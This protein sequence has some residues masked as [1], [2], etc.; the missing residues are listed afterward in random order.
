MSGTRATLR[1]RA[2]LIAAPSV[3]VLVLAAVALG[4][5]VQEIGCNQKAHYALVRAL[6]DGTAIVDEY[7]PES[8]DLA[9]TD[10]HYYA[11]KAPGLAFAVLP[12]YLA[13]DAAGAMPDDPRTAIW[14]LGLFGALVPALLAAA[15]AGRLAERV[16]P[17]TGAFVAAA[18]ALGTLLLPFGTLL[19]AHALAAALALGAFALLW[20]DRPAPATAALAGLLVG[21]AVVVEHPAALVAPV[22]GAYALSRFGARRAGAFAGGAAAGVLPLLAY[23]Y[24]A[25]G[26]VTHFAVVDAISVA[27]NTGHDV[28]G[29]HDR[30]VFGALAPSTTVALEL[31]ASARG[32]LTVTPVVAAGVAGLVLL[33]RRG[34]RAEAF[35][36]AAVAGLYLLWNSG[37]TSPFGGPFGGDSPGARY[38][39]PVLPFLAPGIA[40]ALREAFWPTALLAALSAVF[41]GLAT[42]TEPMLN[43][44]DTGRWWEL[45]SKGEFTGGVVTLLGGPSGVWAVLPFFAGVAAAA[46]VAAVATPR[47]GTTRGALIAAAGVVA[48]WVVVASAAPPLLERGRTL[49]ALAVLL[50]GAAAAYVA[51]R[52][53][54]A[55]R[56]DA[57]A[58]ARAAA[59]GRGARP[60]LLTG[61]LAASVL[62][63]W[64]GATSTAPADGYDGAAHVQYAEHVRETGELPV[65]EDTYE[66]ASPPAFHWLSVRGQEL[67]GGVGDAVEKVSDGPSGPAG[68]VL[69]LALLV[70]GTWLAF[71][72]RRR[73]GVLLLGGAG[74]LLLLEVLV[75]SVA[76]E[77]RIGQ[78]IS[79]ASTAA[80]L[81]LAWLL[82]REAWPGETARPIAVAALAAGMPVL[83]RMGAMFHPEPLFAA[84]ALAAVLVAVRAARREWPLRHAAALGLLLGLGALTRQTT[85]IVVVALA[86]AVAV[87]ARRR[88]LVFG[89]VVAGVLLLVAG[90]WWLHQYDRYGNPIQSNLE[91]E[92]YLLAEGQPRS[93]YVSFPARDLVLHPFRPAFE[94]ELLPMIHA[95]VWGDWFGGQ[96]DLWKD[97]GGAARFFVST[98]SVL[99]LPA[100]VL[101]V[102]ALFAFGVPALRR[103]LRGPPRG[104]DVVFATA[105]LVAALSWTAFVVTLVRYPQAGGDPV[106]ASYMLYLVPLFALALVRAG[107]ALWRRRGLWRIAVGAWIA[108]YAASFVGYLLTSW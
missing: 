96:H 30:G 48:A 50:A 77:W 91:R 63:A 47:S 34:F 100:S 65:E 17:A 11:A 84:L 24:W 36:V 45:A 85:G 41:V 59:A 4:S 38:L 95:D 76:T 19:F 79:V 94:N 53:P 7:Q 55:A 104:P 58:A 3:V 93:F 20:R 103:L 6:A 56:E 14:V 98:Q 89:A 90:P 82:G 25:F 27:G 83:S 75:V 13:L 29:G 33:A 108:L 80:I 101:A 69:W 102:G 87:A 106:K 8:C 51:V 16:A 57:A 10:G 72:P 31:L 18:L 49:A 39:V 70:A 97:P 67:A 46:G 78:A 88:A 73:L 23:N 15:I 92:G 1:R 86:V 68:R 9:Y 26:S 62:V 37:L 22:L 21:L 105:L 28:V 99:G 74:T 107:S 5:L 52:G 12:I 2:A 61:L 64:H 32:L 35:A 42:A 66:F 54:V 40:L 44:V 60:A 71:G 43:G 81:V